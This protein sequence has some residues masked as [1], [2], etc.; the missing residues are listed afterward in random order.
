MT[1]EAKEARNEYYREYRK[2]NP[3]KVKKYNAD[4]WIRKAKQAAGMGADKNEKGNY[5]KAV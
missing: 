2:K 5:S 4:Y 1:E 3:D